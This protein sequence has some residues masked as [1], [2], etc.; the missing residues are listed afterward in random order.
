MDGHF[1]PNLT[2]GAP[3][4]TSLRKHLSNDS[5]GKFKRA[6]FDVHLMV[7]NPGDFIKDMVR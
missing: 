4:I 3:V 5:S 1:V 7:S 6:I 2:F